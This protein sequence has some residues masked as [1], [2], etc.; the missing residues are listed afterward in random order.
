M[1]AGDVKKQGGQESHR[2]P[3]SI[4]KGRLQQES[5]VESMPHDRTHVPPLV[6]LPGILQGPTTISAERCLPTATG[7]LPAF[8]AT[9][10]S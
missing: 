4:C 5:M 3:G 2:G 1:Q 8:P 10:C 6:N 9:S 7:D